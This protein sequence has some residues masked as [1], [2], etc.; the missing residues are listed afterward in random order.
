MKKRVPESDLG[1]SPTPATTIETSVT[2]T[3]KEKPPSLELFLD[4][5]DEDDVDE[6]KDKLSCSFSKEV[7]GHTQLKNAVKKQCGGVYFLLL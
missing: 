4:S 6:M 3:P 1:E 7:T 5:G 2:T